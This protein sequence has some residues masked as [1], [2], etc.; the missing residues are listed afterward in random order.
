[1]VGHPVSF[2]L[3]GFASKGG[4]SVFT[5]K[6]ANLKGADQNPTNKK[7]SLFPTQILAEDDGQGCT[8][9]RETPLYGLPEG[10]IRFLL[11]WPFADQNSR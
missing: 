1:M 10:W 7:G 6:I 11:P 4:P 8:Q 9:T 2:L 5:N 3:N